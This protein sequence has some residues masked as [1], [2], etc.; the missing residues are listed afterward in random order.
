MSITNEKAHWC[1]DNMKVEKHPLKNMISKLASIR[2]MQN[3]ENAFKIKR[4]A[5]R[6]NSAHI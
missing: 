1:K 3:T 2:Q 5:I 4:P 6:N